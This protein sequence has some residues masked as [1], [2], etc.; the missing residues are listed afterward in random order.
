MEEEITLEELLQ[1]IV[2]DKGGTP[3]EYRDLMEYIAYHETGPVAPGLPDQR[4]DPKARQYTYDKKLKKYVQDGLGRGL[5]MYEAG[6]GKSGNSAVN[7]LYNYLTKT[8]NVAAPK[9]V[10]NLQG[11]NKNVDVSKLSADQQKMLFLADHRMRDKSNFSELWDGTKDRPTWWADYHWAGDAED[12]EKKIQAFTI[13]EK[14]L[15]ST[16]TLKAKEEENEMKKNMAPYLSESNKTD[17]FMGVNT[18]KKIMD[19][20]LGLR[21]SLVDSLPKNK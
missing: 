6:E 19:G 13:S 7:R 21:S 17:N 5:F 20:L 3:Q 9:W 15:D 14:A 18:F 11:L 4:M 16:K 12:Y 2:E 8:K 10:E 1:F